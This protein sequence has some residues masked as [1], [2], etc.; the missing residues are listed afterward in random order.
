MMMVPPDH[1]STACPDWE[2]RIE[3]GLSLVPDLPLFG[4]PA[5]KA[6][7]IFKR[8]RVPDMPGQ[9]RFGD[10]SR[11]WVFDLVRAIFGSLDPETQR[12][13]VSE[14]FVMI[15][16]GNAKTTLAAAIMLTAIIV[17]ARP[18]AE[19]LI[20]APTI[21]VANRG[22]SQAVGM[23]RADDAL[24]KLFHVQE[25]LRRIRNHRTGAVLEV[26]AADTGVVTGAMATFVLID[27]THELSRSASADKVLTEL[28][29][30]MG[31]RPDGFLIQITTQ[32]KEQPQGIFAAELKKARM[33]RDG[34][35]R[36]PLLAILYELPERLTKD[37]GWRAP[38]TWPMVNP[39]LGVSIDG[40]FLRTQMV[41]KE[42]EG[43]E[44]L[45]LFASQHFNVEIGIG[46]RTDTWIGAQFWQQCAAPG[47][48]TLEEIRARSS[49]V[50]MGIDGGG[51]DD[52]LGAALIGRDKNSGQ[53]L[54][55]AHAWAQ[56]EVL[57]RRK[58]IAPKLQDYAADG[59][60]TLCSAPGQAHEELAALVKT[61]EEW[62]LFPAENAIGLDH[63]QLAPI[64]EAFAQVGADFG[65][66]AGI[67]Q[68]IR[69]RGAI[70]HMEHRLKARGLLHSGA[71]MMNWVMGNAKARAV[72]SAV[73]IEKVEAG[74]AKIDPLIAL[75]NAAELMGRNPQAGSERQN[76]DSYFASLEGAA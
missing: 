4:D 25:H 2:A 67:P 13:M 17:N 59:D 24:S 61:I 55:W 20:V 49:V 73:V 54:V 63:G 70:W 53:W 18:N 47:G 48:L 38:E 62:G 56:P 11:P 14:F 71:R 16:K 40:E 65:V 26:K 1:W 50:V 66:L 45:A 39:N 15:P 68:G 36:L 72:G 12:R 7:E 28:R 22:F 58:E 6:L 8:L 74:K 52:L 19:A 34:K 35:L 64:L 46:L 69:L 42:M 10:V 33:V 76:M 3:A 75:L 9:P 27:E 5:N 60:V 23:I 29:G 43:P 31:K 57:E 41:A 51:L 30:S 21:N 44:A 37:D 32:S